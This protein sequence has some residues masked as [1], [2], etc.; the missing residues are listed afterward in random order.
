MDKRR[1]ASRAVEAKLCGGM[2]THIYSEDTSLRAYYRDPDVRQ[3]M[4]EFLGGDG[5]DSV[6]SRFI[7]GGNATTANGH[8]HVRR[9]DEFLSGL[10]QGF[11]LCRSLWDRESLIADLDLEY[12]N[13]DHPAEAWLEPERVFDL[14]APVERITRELL[15]GFG[16]APLHFQSGRGHHFTWQIR[17][18]SDACRQLAALARGPASLWRINAQPH[19]PAGECIAPSLGAAFAGLGLVLEFLAHRIKETAAP[20][21]AIPVELTAVEVGPRSHG[22]E[23][24]SIDL[25]EYGD[26]L[27]ARAVRVPF[28]AYLKPWQQRT[29][30][31][32]SVVSNLPPLFVIPLHGFDAREGSR[33]M[34]SPELVIELARSAATSIPEQSAGMERLVAAYRRSELAAFHD[35]FYAEEHDPPER[36]PET[37]D[38]TP[39]DS[40]PACVR[41]VLEAPND[42]LLRPAGMRLV[43]RAMLA[44]GWHPR[45]IAGLIRSKFERDYGWGDQWQQYDPASRADFYVRT[46]A[47]LFATGRDDLVDFNCVSARE[48]GFCCNGPCSSNLAELRQ[49]ALDRRR[50]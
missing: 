12:V 30:L 50:L 18:D 4:L 8:L 19:P 49:A 7:A 45:H 10:D 14:Q 11:E 22:R 41:L 21:S 38:C 42:L 32:E 43:T 17:Q 31:G 1:V 37:Y 27:H 25:S 13:F 3:R 48:A 9:V 33:I 23:M 24:I 26:P 39:M 29:Q 6:T 15:L 5:V 34:R 40:L 47:G 20:L 36:W 44:H 2:S 28:S 46:F 16:I 35:Y